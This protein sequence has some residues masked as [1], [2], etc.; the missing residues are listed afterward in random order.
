VTGMEFGLLGPLAI[1]HD[2]AVI[3][4]TPGKQR[5]VL[6]TLLLKAN[7]MVAVDELA[8]A[9]WG[10]EIPASA[11][12]TMQ[13]YVMRLRK[14]LGEAGHGRIATQPGGY[15][16][17]VEPGEL[18]VSR[19]EA[20][21]G[22]ARAAMRDSSWAAA[23]DQARAALALWRG[24]PLADV[25]S[26][27]LA[28]R[29]VP[30][31]AELRLQA[32]ETHIDAELHLGQHSEVIGELR[33]LTAADP[34]RE[35]LHALLML[36]LY[37]DGRQGEALAAYQRARTVIV[38]ELGTEPGPEL[39]ELHQRMLAADPALA[40]PEPAWPAGAAVPSVPRELPGGTRHFTGRADELAALTGLLDQAGDEPPTV[41]I[42]AI[43]GTAGV[44]KTALA[45]QWAHQVADR[46][47]DGQLYVNLRGYDP[48]QPVSAADA[49]AGFLRALGVAGPD[50][51]AEQSERAARYRSLLAGKRML[52]VLDNAGDVEQVRPLLP[53][54]PGCVVVVTSRDALAGL[55]AREGATR[56]DL[57]LFPLGDA[58]S[59]LRALVG[60]RV[61]ADHGAAAALAGRCVRLPLAL[62]VAAELAATRPEVSLAE[63][64]DEL[65][66]H[67]RRLDVLEAGGDPRT[68]VRAVF[69]WSYRHL[70]ADAARAFRLM[71]LHP[72]TDCDPGAVAA[73]TGTTARQAG[74]MLDVL[75]R[76][77]LAQLAAPGRYGMHD[78]LRA[79][80]AEQAAAV[81]SP[82]ARRLALTCL[83]DYY[84]AA[85]AAAMDALYP[86]EK[87]RRPQPPPPAGPVPPPATEAAREWL[88]AERS[89]LV[90]VTA[91]AAS[92]GWPSHAIALAG[93][94]YRY[95]ENGGH[96]PDAQA[97][98]GAALRAARETGDVPAQADALKNLGLVDTWQGYYQQAAANLASALELY[99]QIGDLVGQARTLSN[100]GIASWRH[101]Q[102]QQ[103]AG[104]LRQ[105]VE[106][107]RETG[108]RFGE[109][110]SLTNLGLVQMRRGEVEQA[111]G[112]ERESLAICRELG[113]RHGEAIALVNL[114]EVL[115]R[116]RSYAEAEEH[117]GDA[118]AIFRELGDRRGQGYVLLNLGRSLGG[119]GR[120]QQAAGVYRQALILFREIGDRTT[121]AEALNE[122]GDALSA[123][124]LPGQARGQH[125]EA[126]ALA[127][128]TRARYVQ[129]RA[130][131][132]LAR[133]F[134]A[135][136]EAGRADQHWRQALALYTDLGAPEADQV[137][138]QLTEAVGGGHRGR[139]G[140]RLPGP[141][142]GNLSA[143]GPGSLFGRRARAR[144]L[145][146]GN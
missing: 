67:Q 111:V 21:L 2:E 125:H 23:A 87:H 33:Q 9:L 22:A 44:G 110:R 96:L 143:L 10:S 49:L 31:L 68:A 74:R 92:G 104:Q 116:Q 132:G 100:L 90:S 123:A 14:S 142:P 77:H 4:V 134:K 126:L 34:L 105:S 121:E 75:A 131:D 146:Q 113:D 3:T 38:E 25:E 47:P 93:I 138:A 112:H 30:R 70:D 26:E 59:L 35:R 94:L 11:R 108:D 117:L 46:F 16:I 76:A 109:S 17:A 58:V 15:L 51:P 133:S 88:D 62:R 145:R 114:S 122:L 5:V 140:P 84:L 119:R 65:A 82:Q 50:I 69:S 6:A 8:E 83:F 95:L 27:V 19:C 24:E 78:L 144:P 102:L 141:G 106:L 73:L 28:L 20:L 115:C 45:L 127:R 1:R 12:A 36:A 40:A 120:F 54:N 80:A 61:D 101:G 85:A 39:R 135:T 72:A 130:H 57:D 91:Y 55:V 37:R 124:G 81:D 99:R 137:R 129:A 32:L 63:L 118:Q 53:G 60:I 13:N 107:C 66:D 42:S 64:S 97:V 43:G 18:D 98:F 136:G 56:L 103:A 52:V 89:C 41:V 79:Y 128:Q 86:A 71:G 48:G 139:P 29:E 7:R